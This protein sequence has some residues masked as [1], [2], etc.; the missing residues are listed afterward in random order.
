MGRPRKRSKKEAEAPN[1]ESTLL[2]E[3]DSGATEAEEQ[4]QSEDALEFIRAIDEYRRMK[5]R[6]F[7]TWTEVFGILRSLGYRKGPAHD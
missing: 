5:N 6:P 2:L 7:P 1:P 4:V 3:Q